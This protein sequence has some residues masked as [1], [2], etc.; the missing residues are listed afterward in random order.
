MPNRELREKIRFSEKV[1]NLTDKEFRLF[2]LLIATASD[3]GRY[4]ADPRLVRVAC[5]PYETED[6]KSVS[7]TLESLHKKEMITIYAV[8]GTKYLQMHQWRGRFRSYP[9]YPEPPEGLIPNDGQLPVKRKRGSRV[10]G[11]GS[12]G[13]GRGLD[14]PT[15]R[16]IKDYIQQLINM[17]L[18]EKA[19]KELPKN[20]IKRFYA[21]VKDSVGQS[22]LDLVK[23]GAAEK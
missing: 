23:K 18:Q 10:E 3:Y 14:A 6:L 5:F 21:K 20:H 2:T 19:G 13:E 9:K 8:D 16:A 17:R 7:A 11:R 12:R 22:G 15:A 4:R 1:A